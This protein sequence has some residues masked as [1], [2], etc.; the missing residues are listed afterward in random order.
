[1]KFRPLTGSKLSSGFFAGF[2]EGIF[3]W[4]TGTAEQG[5]PSLHGLVGMTDANMLPLSP[6]TDT[7]ITVTQ[8]EMKWERDRKKRTPAV[9]LNLTYFVTSLKLWIIGGGGSLVTHT[10]DVFVWIPF[11]RRL[12]TKAGESNYWQFLKFIFSFFK[13]LKSSTLWFY[14]LLLTLCIWQ[15]WTVFFFP[16]FPQQWF[17][18]CF[19]ESNTTPSKNALVCSSARNLWHHSWVRLPDQQSTS[20][21]TSNPSPQWCWVGSV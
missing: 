9:T 3:H 10:V 21:P 1:M 14:H 18:S 12:I 15:I 20:P 2:Y 19:K 5:N 7:I 6:D 13:L 8:L 11:T 16:T 17:L 4:L